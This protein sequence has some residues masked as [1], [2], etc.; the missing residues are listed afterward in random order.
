[1]NPPLLALS[2]FG[3][4]YQPGAAAT[5]ADIRF[6]LARGRCLG[7]VGESGSGKSTLAT[8]LIGLLP[9]GAEAWGEGQF[10][11]SLID[12]HDQRAWRVR[13]G[14]RI[15]FVFQDAAA[16]LHP[17]RSVQSQLREMLASQSAIAQ[18]LEEVGLP[19]DAEFLRRLP[20][21]ISGGQR[22]RLMLA[23]ALARQPDLLIADEP[24]S[25]LDALASAAIR[26][27]LLQLKSE[28]GLALILVSHDLD[29][30]TA[31]ADD[32]LL[33]RQGRIV[34]SGA[35][36]TV[37]QGRTEAYVQQLLRC[38]PRLLDNPRRL[39]LPATPAPAPIIAA[40]MARPA[41][42]VRQL[43]VHYRGRR[44]LQVAAM[45]LASGAVLGVIGASGSGKSTLALA[46]LQLI[47]SSAEQLIVAGTDPRGLRGSARKHWRGQVQVVFQ[48][49][50]TALDPMQNV[51]AAIGEALDLHQLA[52][53]PAARRERIGELLTSVHLD[54]GL[55]T[56]YP[57]Q[58]SGGQKQRV[59]I[60]R[61]LAVRPSLLICDEAI[62]ALDVS[63]QAEVLN[64]LADLREQQRLTL[65]FIGH[66]L[67]AISFIA[68]QLLVLDQGQI[69]EAGAT[70]AVLRHPQ[71]PV[72]RALIA[73]LP[74]RLRL[75]DYPAN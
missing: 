48:D 57:H 70:D 24:T 14:Q 31:V 3:M 67:A 25:A 38:R 46:L 49:P 26:R 8:A 44:A 63:V 27:L 69:V 51:A 55:A 28:R 21:Q 37:L 59:A 74:E 39:G 10:D 30:V 43:A 34:S 18:A 64:L 52:L 35:T 61:A 75:S 15:G 54:A 36:A 9:P 22:Q 20:Q 56:R 42:L 23:L 17:L 58:L 73:A 2:G 11:R 41:L 16:S 6:D 13:R 62:S 5:L 4:R 53:T 29:T 12:W 71:H 65:V 66:D 72:T 60:A 32:L 45:D 68:D 40:P 7:V 33:L 1:M 19:A 50:G 47:D